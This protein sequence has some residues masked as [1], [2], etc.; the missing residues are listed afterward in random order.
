M[1][2]SVI[3]ICPIL[4]T[5]HYIRGTASIFPRHKF[6]LFLFFSRCRPLCL[7]FSIFSRMYILESD[8]IYCTHYY[9]YLYLCQKKEKN[10]YYFPRSE[11]EEELKPKLYTEW[12][13]VTTEI[14]GD[15]LT[16]IQ[17]PVTAHCT[18]SASYRS[19]S[20]RLCWSSSGRRQTV[21][22]VDTWW[23]YGGCQRIT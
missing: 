11:E 14:S 19:A 13:L 1:T 5:V 7:M 23:A 22:N 20:S 21:D 9:I 18:F 15:D 16:T 10:K 8:T 17:P 3:T 6:M 2:T 4:I 12:W